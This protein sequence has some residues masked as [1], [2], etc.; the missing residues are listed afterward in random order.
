MLY[1]SLRWPQSA[2]LS[3]EVYTPC[4]SRRGP[5]SP[6]LIGARVTRWRRLAR[7]RWQLPAQNCAWA[8]AAIGVSLASASSRQVQL[9]FP[10]QP[11]SVPA[12]AA[13]GSGSCAARR[14]AGHPAARYGIVRYT[15]C[16]AAWR[17]RA[18][19]VRLLQRALVQWP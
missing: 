5:R 16:R 15:R 1:T 6:Y 2:V 13:I 10:R 18:A 17:H 19:L 8:L 11:R 9:R 7:P 12:P 4:G 3:R 14:L